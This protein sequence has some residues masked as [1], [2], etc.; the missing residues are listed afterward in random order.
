MATPDD[1]SPHAGRIRALERARLADG[2]AQ[3]PAAAPADDD[4]HAPGP[5]RRLD[6]ALPPGL[7]YHVLGPED[8]PGDEAS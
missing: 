1:D 2:V 6:G 7:A 5:A 3:R 4:G 8:D